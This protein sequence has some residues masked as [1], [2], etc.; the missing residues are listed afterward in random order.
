M[1]KKALL[2]QMRR[3]ARKKQTLESVL[4]SQLE[5]PQKEKRPKQKPKAAHKQTKKRG[6]RVLELPQFDEDGNRIVLIGRNPTANGRKVVVRKVKKKSVLSTLKKAVVYARVRALASAGTENQAEKLVEL[7]EGLQKARR[8]LT[9]EERRQRLAAMPP[10]Q[11]RWGDCAEVFGNTPSEVRKF[12]EHLQEHARQQ[13]R[14]APHPHP[15]APPES[16]SITRNVVVVTSATTFCSAS[17][18]GARAAR[19]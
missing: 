5:A 19:S 2:E 16:K 9:K 10:R 13:A 11:C 17:G 6:P 4:L 15:P 14:F 18:P 1:S 7:V 3:D 12:R 8:G